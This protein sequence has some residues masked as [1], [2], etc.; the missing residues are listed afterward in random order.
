M[1]S[2]EWTAQ[3]QEWREEL[4]RF[5]ASDLLWH[6]PDTRTRVVEL[7]SLSEAAIELPVSRELKNL[8]KEQQAHFKQS[9]VNSLCVTR[10]CLEWCDGEKHVLSPW[11]LSEVFAQEQKWN[12]SI[13]LRC[14]EELFVNPVL[15]KHF[16][17]MGLLPKEWNQDM[18][19]EG[20]RFVEIHFLGNFHYHRYTL[21]RDMDSYIRDSNAE[22]TLLGHFFSGS[23]QQF[24]KD[25]APPDFR[26]SPADYYQ[27]HVLNRLAQGENLTVVGPPGS[28]KS[29]LITN[30]IVQHAAVG[31][32]VLCTS[33]KPAA[34]EV[35]RNKLEECGLHVFCE[36]VFNESKSRSTFIDSLKQ[37][38]LFLEDAETERNPDRVTEEVYTLTQDRLRL[39]FSRLN[40]IPELPQSKQA[41][42]LFQYAPDQ[43]VWQ[44]LHP[45]IEQ[46][47]QHFVGLTG[48]GFHK[49]AFF[50]FKPEIVRDAEAVLKLKREVEYTKKDLK[51]L[52]ELLP[53]FVQV[54]TPGQWSKLNRMA[55]HAQLMTHELFVHSARLMEA[56]PKAQ[57]RFHKLAAEYTSVVNKIESIHSAD[58]RKWTKNWS[59]AEV[60]EATQVFRK[61]HWWTRSYHKWKSRFLLDYNPA[62]F[63]TELALNALTTKKELVSFTR[64]RLELQSKLAEWGVRHAEVELPILTQ[65]MAKRNAAE[66][67]LWNEVASLSPD[68]KLTLVS[69]SARIARINRFLTVYVYAD[70]EFSISE[71]MNALEKE[72]GYLSATA[73]DWYTLTSSNLSIWR[74]CAEVID[75]DGVQDNLRWHYLQ[76]FRE[77]NP[78]LFAYSGQA[79]QT[80]L[81][82]LEGCEQSY[83]QYCIDS[84]V[85]ERKSRFNAYHRILSTPAAK[86]SAE[87]KKQ[88]EILRNG[89]SLLVKEFSKSRNHLSLREL[90]ESPAR[91]WIELLK[92]ILLMSPLSVSQVLPNTAGS[93]DLLVMDEA[94]QLPLVHALP[95]LYRS[96]QVCV[97]GDPMQ[98]APS[99]Y[100]VQGAREREDV[101]SRSL[102]HFPGITLKH[103]YRSQHP[104]L[105]GFSNRFFYQNE[106]LV[107]PFSQ[108]TETMGLHGYRCPTGR[109]VDRV[110]EVEAQQVAGVL[111][112]LLST[113]GA[114]ETVG[115]V[116][117]S[118]A[119]L[120]VVQ[121]NCSAV[122]EDRVSYSTLEQVQGD[123]FDYVVIT[124]GYGPDEQGETHL[125]FGPVNQQGGEKRLN[126]LMSRA[127]KGIH[128]VYSLNPD[129]MIPNENIGVELL[130]KC[131]RQLDMSGETE[132]NDFLKGWGF[133][134]EVNPTTAQIRVKNP[135]HAAH[136]F[137]K[138]RTLLALASMRG[139]APTLE[140]E[141][142]RFLNN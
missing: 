121:E 39:K 48:Y 139:W 118:E 117:F 47:H 83:F 6:I 109:Y 125:R 33:E 56:N 65:L 64:K 38:W 72:W 66:P 42:Q 93:I 1:S 87:D 62:V 107:F 120:K 55:I 73:S 51:A 135:Q 11:L 113:I 110:N 19:P 8:F 22:N 31:R 91:N 18:L 137:D 52:A 29:Q 70:K 53:D 12:Q 40:D 130:G 27:Q 96:R 86:L 74:F 34:L 116:A 3:I 13:A 7:P 20:W 41:T 112:T 68:T 4:L 59:E 30:L 14:A 50:F 25:L 37:T 57:A 94:S 129:T 100:F 101:L 32:K 58:A 54:D 111:H 92:P 49:A 24:A 127:R 90:L 128:L 69:E 35:L 141:K 138:L 17:Q 79:L 61:A 140:F 46:L 28:G 9:G 60:D 136:G 115:V 10:M 44:Q 67:D 21:L 77:R 36:P 76:R 16:L 114:H 75:W 97:V 5:S 2:T 15:E 43:E 134:A 23:T 104:D 105:I 45:K 26:I 63:S 106:L 142:D 89:R 123:E 108:L 126:V 98:M 95:S 82:H 99:A 80:D 122:P 102:F 81:V 103:H 124:V 85:Q 132:R 131:I 88:K 119:Q 78:E 71:W 84:F 133:E